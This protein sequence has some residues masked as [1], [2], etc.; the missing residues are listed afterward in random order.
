[1][2]TAAAQPAAPRSAALH[3][4]AHAA[5]ARSAAVDRSLVVLVGLV[6]LVVGTLVAL[7]SYGVFGTGRAGRPLLDP[8]VVDALRA[9]PTAARLIAIA[10]GVVLLVLGL[11]WTARSLRPERRPD[12][13]LD[14][15]PD[16]AIVV[17]STAVADAVANQAATLPGVGRAR[18]RVVGSAATPAL[19]VV[20]WL[21]DDADVREILQRLDAE[22]LDAARTSLGLEALAT[23]VRLELEPTPSAPRVA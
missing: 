20:L 15:G 23:A 4:R 22:V 5:V 14:A 16:T 6:L 11:T 2:S 17:T 21:T 1:M 9:Q 10:A 13:V 19:R 12:L 8:M 18:A 3:K 7:L